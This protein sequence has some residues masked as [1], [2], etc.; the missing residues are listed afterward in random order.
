[1]PGVKLNPG[2]TPRRNPSLT[3]MTQISGFQWDSTDVL[4]FVPALQAQY[5]N[6]KFR[7]PLKYGKGR[8][9]IDVTG[10]L[11]NGAMWLDVERGDA[12]VADVPGWLDERARYGEGG[13]YCN[14]DT[15]PAVEQA[16][17]D[18]PHLLWIGTLDGTIDIPLPPGTGHLVAVQAFPAPWLPVH[19]DLSVV[20]DPGYWATHAAAVP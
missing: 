3:H 2:K 13:I 18:R 11:P 9:F 7:A 6:G 8:V 20:V 17:G 12:T 4:P 10:G 15:L 16:A 14:R 5:A 19:A 1:M